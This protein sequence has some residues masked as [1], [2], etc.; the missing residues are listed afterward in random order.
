MHALCRILIAVVALVL[1]LSPDAKSGESDVGIVLMHGKWADP[2]APPIQFLATALRAEGFKVITPIMPWGRKRMYDADYPTVLSEIEASVEILRKKGAKHIIVAGHSFGANASIAYAASGREIDGVI[3][4]APG[5]CPDL[6]NFGASVAKARQ[7]IA[8]GKAEETASF[9]DNPQ[10]QHRTIS[11]TAKI[12]LSF[13]D[14]DGLGA[15]PK[16]AALIPRPVPFLWVVGTHDRIY[17]YGED[18]VFNKVPK[19]PRNMYL[20]VNADHSG[21]P[22]VAASQIVEWIIAHAGEP[23][24]R[25]QFPIVDAHGHIGASFK[26]SELI[27]EMD[28]NGVSKLIVMAR[29]YPGKDAS[30]LPGDDRLALKLAET[31]PGRFYPLV[32]MQH[33][34]LTGAQKWITPD[35]DVESLIQETERKLASGKFFGIGEFIVRHWAYSPGIHAE[36]DNPIYSELMRRF[37]V[38]AAKYDVPMVIHMEGYPTLVADFSKL[39]TENP[40]TRYV[41]AHNCGRSKAEVIR[42]LLSRFQNLFCDLGGM[43]NATTGYGSGWPRKEE[44]TALIER[45]GEL[46]PEMK[47]LYEEFPDRFMVGTDVAHAPAMRFYKGRVQRFSKLLEQLNPETRAKIA[48]QNAIR[49]YKIAR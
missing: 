5:H 23:T 19:H 45:D 48:E 15:M 24:Q 38:L 16:S 10:G 32:G 46:F 1:A 4:I 47:S 2:A 17:R 39:I 36:Q 21:T 22:K 49:I 12:Y 8:K 33:P 18:Y 7:M 41:W 27:E 13:F 42:G 25:V 9:D 6:D 35:A 26:V 30:D 11:T 40:G 14:P 34:L 20:V 37:S 31:Y 43:T 3:A 29:A 44:F 28:K